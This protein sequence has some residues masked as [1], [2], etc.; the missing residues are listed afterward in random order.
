M[1]YY[2][3]NRINTNLYNKIVLLLF[4]LIFY[5]SCKKDIETTEKPN[6]LWLVFEDMSPQFIGA[7]GNNVVKTPTIDSLIN[8]GT[9]FDAAFSTG[10]VCS[11]SRYTIITGTRTFEYGTGHHRSNYPIPSHILGFPQFLKDSG[12]HTSNNSKRDYNHKNQWQMTKTAW[13]ESNDKAGWWNR[14]N[15]PFFSVFNF[16]NSHQSRTFTNPYDNY[17]KRILDN[18]EDHEILKPEDIILPSFYKDTPE[19]RRELSRTYNAMK[20]TDKEIDTL[21]QQ[22]KRDGL[23]E[24]TIIFLYS[25]HGG[26]ALRT[27]T[28]GTALGHQVP[29]T[30]VFPKKYKHLNPFNDKTTKQPVTFEDLAPTVLSLA[31]IDKPD[32]MTGKAFLGEKAEAQK[33]AVASSDRSGED[34]DL[35]RSISDGTFFYTRVFYPRRPFVSW[36]KYFDYSQSR[37]LIREYHK[38]KTLD[39]KQ[40]QLFDIRQTEYLHDLNN[41]FWQTN[42]LSKNIK[43]EKKLNELRNALDEKLLAAKDV[44]FLPEYYLDSI[45]KVT[46]AY[47]FKE[48]DAYDFKNIYKI[49]KMVGDTTQINNQIEALQHSNSIIR[50]WALLGISALKTSTLKNY[51]AQITDAFNDTF[52]P[53][54]IIAASLLYL[55]F[56]DETAKEYIRKIMLHENTIIATQALQELIYYPKEK[57]IDFTKDVEKILVAYKTKKNGGNVTESCDIFLHKFTGKPLYYATHW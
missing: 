10:A 37:Q 31:G 19:L 43:Y 4:S 16:N 20:K 51:K 22:L 47:E 18:L 24:S 25:D 8:I 6:I 54:K 40:L 21:L 44:H 39:D 11:P 34:Y 33:Y 38:E 2:T 3:K 30:V 23:S 41:D 9:R 45:T 14:K 15:Q 52:I 12:Y 48:S 46:T 56:N 57:A 28:E 49:A 36:Q 42:N 26:G 50:Y 35:T 29:M 32:Y 53:N 5:S 1:D 55:Y 27:K 13:V 17:K 7:Y